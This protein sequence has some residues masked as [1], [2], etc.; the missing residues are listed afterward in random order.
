M[1][2][3]KQWKKSLLRSTQFTSLISLPSQTIQAPQ[4]QYYYCPSPMLIDPAPMDSSSPS[5]R[6]PFL[7]RFC[8]NSSQKQIKAKPL[9]RFPSLK[10]FSHDFPCVFIS[11]SDSSLYL[12]MQPQPTTTL[13][14]KQQTT[15]IC[16][17]LVNSIWTKA[18]TS[19]LDVVWNLGETAQEIVKLWSWSN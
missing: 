5:S 15:A 9:A 4:G 3:L 7:G 1:P 8:S 16:V 13:G 10:T 2:N 12:L 19:N 14:Q 18:Q 6:T 11:A 17:C